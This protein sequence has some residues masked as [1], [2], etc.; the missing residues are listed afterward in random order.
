MPAASRLLP[1]AAALPLLL[2]PRRRPGARTPLWTQRLRAQNLLA[3][4]QGF[5]SFPIMLETYRAC[6]QDV[7]DMPGLR[8]VLEAIRSRRIRVEDVETR[9]ASPFARSLVFSLC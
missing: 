3:V 6:L 4:A 8:E 1:A 9:T 2:L 5:P 7:F